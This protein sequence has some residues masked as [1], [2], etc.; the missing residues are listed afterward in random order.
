MRRQLRLLVC[1]VAVAGAVAASQ[2]PAPPADGA[3]AASTLWYRQPAPQWDHAMPIGNGRLGAMV[4]G[5][6]NRERIQLNEHSLWM[7]GRQDR[8]SPDALKYLPEVRRLLFAGAP[9]DAY[10][11]A[12][13][14]LMGRP[15]R[16]PSY[17][18][19]GDLRLI[20]D[21]EEP[22][23]DYRRELDLDSAI[24]RV[25]YRAGSVR[26]TRE[27]FAS[28]PD[29][30]IVVR[31]GA[32][33]GA[34]FSTSVWIERSQDATTQI[35]G[36]DRLDLVGA[37]AGGKG[38]AFQ[39]T[40]KVLPEGGKLETFPERILVDGVSAVTLLIAANTSYRGGDPAK[41]TARQ[42]A[43]AAARPYAELRD[44]HVADHRALFR[45]AALR[46]GDGDEEAAAR[47]TDE[48]LERVKRGERDLE[49]RQ[50][51]FSVRTLPPHSQQPPRRPTRE[52][53][54]TLERQHEPAVGQRLSPEHQPADELLA[55]G[56]DEPR[57]DPPAVVRLR[58]VAARTRT[59]DRE[60]PLRRPRLRRASHHGRLGFY[61][62]RRSASIGLVGDRR[63]LASSA[64]LGALPVRRRSRLPRKVIS[65]DEGSGGVLS[66][67]PRS[68]SK[69]TAGQ[70]PIRLAREPLSPAERA[71]RHS[72]HGTVDGSPDHRRPVPP[73]DPRRRTP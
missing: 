23:S 57:R 19:L 10:A 5:S 47:P 53:A 15:Q 4:F 2:A 33:G 42:I 64:P 41:M 72:V 39:G 63:R 61:R 73:D 66:R 44:R 67:L 31:L 71:G 56:G 49:S 11:L 52:P 30:A 55:G 68:R 69:R 17:Q 25:S 65:R 46:L 3:P 54:G 7:G 34:R 22:I 70:R 21:H 37:L 58:R 13:R 27:I 62:S 35:V 12:E 43:D 59:A 51:V 8:N 16:L 45:R 18:T 9:L 48:R 40:V 32:A 50:P 38:L 60:R 1:A 14:Y 36:S 24:V 28:H 20:F 6:V 29:Q 26:L